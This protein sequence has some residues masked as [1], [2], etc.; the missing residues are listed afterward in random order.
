MQTSEKKVMIAMELSSLVLDIT[1]AGIRDKY[2]DNISEERMRQ[3]INKRIALKSETE[4]LWSKKKFL[5][6]R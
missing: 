3:E 2:G 5:K 4:N 6:K 1:K